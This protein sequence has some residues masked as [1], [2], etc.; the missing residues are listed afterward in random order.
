MSKEEVDA[1]NSWNDCAL[2]I[3][4]HVILDDILKCVV[5]METTNEI[6]LNLKTLYHRDT[7]FALVYKV[8]SLCQLGWIFDHTRPISEFITNCESER[9]N[10][11]KLRRDSSD[12]YRQ[13]FAIFLK[14][15]KA[16]RDFLLGMISCHHKI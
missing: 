8:G 4:I 13:Q 16:K 6:W 15:D 12:I 11:L 9:L 1:Y 2:V 5:E 3:F 7:A 14:N 10:L